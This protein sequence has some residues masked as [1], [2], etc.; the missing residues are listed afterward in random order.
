VKLFNFTLEKQKISEISQF[1]W[2]FIIYFF[3]GKKSL[4]ESRYIIVAIKPLLVWGI[5]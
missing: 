5:N 4:K 3:V 2:D 1:F